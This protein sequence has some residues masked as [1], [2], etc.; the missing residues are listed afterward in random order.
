[1]SHRCHLGVTT[2]K[3][4]SHAGLQQKTAMSWANPTVASLALGDVPG[5]MKGLVLQLGDLSARDL[6]WFWLWK[7]VINLPQ[8]LGGEWLNHQFLIFPE[9]LG[10]ESSRLTKSYFQRGGLT[11]NQTRS[12]MIHEWWWDRIWFCLM[13]VKSVSSNDSSS[14]V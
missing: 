10:F 14:W 12:W 9:I 3:R 6:R 1:M 11:T 2:P 4:V 13:F 8:L 7:M 5:K